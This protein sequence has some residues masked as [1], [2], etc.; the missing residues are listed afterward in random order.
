[1]VRVVVVVVLLKVVGFRRQY[2][3]IINDDRKTILL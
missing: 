3:G 2:Q 1:M